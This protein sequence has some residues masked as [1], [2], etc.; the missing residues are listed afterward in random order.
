MAGVKHTTC[1]CKYH[2]HTSATTADMSH[3]QTYTRH[4]PPPTSCR[5]CPATN[6]AQHNLTYSPSAARGKTRYQSRR[7]LRGAAVAFDNMTIMRDASSD[8]TRRR[9]YNPPCAMKYRRHPSTKPVEIRTQLSGPRSYKGVWGRTLMN[10][11]CAPR[12]GLVARWVFQR[13]PSQRGA[14]CQR[15]T[16]VASDPPHADRNTTKLTHT[17]TQSKPTPRLSV[18][19]VHHTTHYVAFCWRDEPIVMRS[20]AATALRH[21]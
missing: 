1:V 3:R 15:N 21:D 5:S 19:P 13:R 18:K 11:K 12:K 20:V 2:N 14:R 8:P 9:K 17:H 6:S 10:E 4:L 7:R 16:L